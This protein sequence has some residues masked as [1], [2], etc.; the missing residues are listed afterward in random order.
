MVLMM[1]VGSWWSESGT[2]LSGIY[3]SY[4]CLV[5]CFFL[6]GLR[7]RTE[8]FLTAVKSYK[9]IVWGILTILL[10]VPI[11]GTQII[12]TIQFATMRE[13]NM[14]TSQSTVVGNVTAIG[15]TEFAFALQV[16]FTV[17]AS[18]S[19]GAILSLLAGGNFPLAMLLMAVTNV[20]AVFTVPPMLVWM[21]DLTSGVNVTR[22]GILM[23]VFSLVA[24]L[25]T[26]IGKLLRLVNAV[27]EK[28]DS[29]NRC[30]HY[31]IITLFLLST[32]PQ[33]SKAQVDEEFNNIVSMNVLIIVGYSSI[34]HVMFSAD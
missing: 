13:D 4:I 23:I 8:E 12:K 2:F 6:C 21:T 10:V 17:P 25:P 5:V 14:T 11:T 18:M 32:W 29:C 15:P 31:A 1:F 34:M 20:A 16:F 7:M 28:V 24:V 30:I 27:A 19:A 3:F 26:I 9:A 22:F 33:V